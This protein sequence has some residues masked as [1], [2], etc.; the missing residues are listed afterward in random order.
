MVPMRRFDFLKNNKSV[1]NE[2]RRSRT[3]LSFFQQSVLQDLL[4]FCSISMLVDNILTLAKVAL[5]II[6]LVGPPHTVPRGY[7][8][9]QILVG[10]N[11]YEGLGNAH[12]DLPHIQL[13]NPSQGDLG[14]F[15]PGT[16]KSPS[17]KLKSNHAWTYD[18][19][20]RHPGEL[21]SLELKMGFKGLRQSFLTGGAIPQ[22]LDDGICMAYLGWVPEHTM[23][24]SKAR[25]GAI[26]GDLFYL[27]GYS[28]YYSGRKVDGKHLRCGCLDGDNT[29]GNSVYGMF[30]DTDVFGSEYVKSHAEKHSYPTDYCRLGI[31]FYPGAY[32]LSYHK[33]SLPQDR[34]GN[35]A[36]LTTGPGAIELCDSS[37]SW[38]RS[39]LS[40]QEGIF[41]DMATNTK[42]PICRNGQTA[43][44]MLYDN[45]RYGKRNL[46]GL[47][48]T[49]TAVNVSQE[50]LAHTSYSLEYF[51]VS[52]INGTMIDDGSAFDQ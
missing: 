35:N 13:G 27:C 19:R 16:V 6:G 51:V 2:T 39:M 11:G 25:A 21:K 38:G 24:N 46:H 40:L 8:R 48:G 23:L 52:D 47:H 43:G 14:A 33:R 32:P 50:A 20:T 28:W 18:I 5:A 15:D 29:N 22:S 34:Y 41:C 3:P 10:K 49:A 12:G 31:W 1:R 42:V 7:I 44:C 30:V 45:N 36:Y 26:T 9:V 4:I 17:V 37:T